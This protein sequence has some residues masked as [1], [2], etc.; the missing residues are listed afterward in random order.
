MAGKMRPLFPDFWTDDRTVVLSAHARLV[1]M[2][3]WNFAC[4]NGHVQD[5]SRQLK[6]RI[7]PDDDVNMTAL[8]DEVAHAHELVDDDVDPYITRSGGW[9]RVLGS[10]RWVVDNR[11]LK[12]CDHPG[13]RELERKPRRGNKGA[14]TGTPG[15]HGA[16]VEMAVKTKSSLLPAAPLDPVVDVLRSKL[17]EHTTLSELRFDTLTRE[18]SDEIVRLVRVHGDDRLRQVALSTCRATPPVH[19]QA[20]LRDWQALPLAGQL[21]VVKRE[22][23]DI[24]DTDRDDAGVCRSCAADQKAMTR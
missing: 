22:R 21:R 3:L 10:D 24:H 17:R 20:F 12:T 8:I 9:I 15:S 11:W 19:V 18:Q 2:G 13:C 7:L 16:D 14:T 5:R 4:D 23:C 6:R 1:F